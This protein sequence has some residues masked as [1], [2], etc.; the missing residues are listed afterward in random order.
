[1][2]SSWV[3]SS[4]NASGWLLKL[5]NLPQ[6]WNILKGTW[7][8]IPKF[9]F[10][11]S[12]LPHFHSLEPS[13]K[14]CRL[15]L[16]FSLP[17]E[18]FHINKY[19]VMSWLIFSGVFFSKADSRHEWGR[20]SRQIL[21]FIWH[22]KSAEAALDEAAATQLRPDEL[23][24]AQQRLEQLTRRQVAREALNEALRRGKMKKYEKHDVLPP[25]SGDL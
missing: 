7:A 10:S 12:T 19:H 5:P 25:A 20:F 22:E 23:R 17:L 4:R 21:L 16:S 3:N 1:M 18:R 2:G 13:L 15:I 14:L 8:R 11:T 6:A 9:P 24:A